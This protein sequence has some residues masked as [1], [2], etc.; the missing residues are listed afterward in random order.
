MTMRLN[1][2]ALYQIKLA[3]AERMLKAANTLKERLQIEV[4]TP[5]PRASRPGEYPRKRTGTGQREVFVIPETPEGVIAN[6]MDV[7][8]GHSNFAWYMPFLEREKGRLGIF[9]LFKEM[10]PLLQAIMAGSDT[11]L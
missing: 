10:Q 9:S 6:G 11:R 5:Y 1:P 8:I 4:D 3:A 7:F 2:D